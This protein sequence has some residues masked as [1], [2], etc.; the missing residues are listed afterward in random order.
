MQSV[1]KLGECLLKYSFLGSFTRLVS[2]LNASEWLCLGTLYQGGTSHC[3]ELG[4]PSE[5][6]LDVVLPRGMLPPGSEEGCC[7]LGLEEHSGTGKG[8]AAEADGCLAGEAPCDKVNGW[9][10]GACPI[11]M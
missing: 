8:G 11:N 1:V 3:L 4:G 10:V 7:L 2:Q 6:V 5:I 9:D